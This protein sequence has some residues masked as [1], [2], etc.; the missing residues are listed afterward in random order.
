MSGMFL[1]QSRPLFFPSLFFFK[2]LFPG[3]K[4]DVSLT[5]FLRN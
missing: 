2:Y 3:E 1:Q 4:T 5:S